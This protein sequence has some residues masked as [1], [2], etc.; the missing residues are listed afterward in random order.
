M[1]EEEV[2]EEESCIGN[3]SF[4]EEEAA[5][6]EKGDDHP[7]FGSFRIFG[8]EEEDYFICNRSFGKKKSPYW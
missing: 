1:G 3:W 2:E 7:F 4:E 8:E 5:A 6:E